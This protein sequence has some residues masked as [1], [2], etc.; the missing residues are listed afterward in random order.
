MS[1]LGVTTYRDVRKREQAIW[2]SKTVGRRSGTRSC[3][4]RQVQHRV[5]SWSSQREVRAMVVRRA[6]KPITVPSVIL[7]VALVAACGQTLQETAKVG[8]APQP[9]AAGGRPLEGTYWKAIELAGKTTPAQDPSREAHLQFQAGRVSGS[10]GC[11]QLTGSYQLNGERV[12]FGQM[13]GTLMACLN[14][15]GTEEP[16]RN[17]LKNASRL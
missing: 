4:R 2:R 13:A 6:P 15:T 10:D 3:I 8:P 5:A 1:L 12:T 9:A 7:L 16:F 11:N 17:A 14:E